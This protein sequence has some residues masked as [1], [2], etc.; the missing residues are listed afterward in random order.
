MVAS[1]ARP[2]Y[3]GCSSQPPLPAHKPRSRQ[4]AYGH[5]LPDLWA[6]DALRRGPSNQ[7]LQ[8]QQGMA[9]GEG[10]GGQ[11]TDDTRH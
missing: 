11:R 8:L 10:H 4:R 3:T 9:C 2:L 7:H 1:L 6:R 5:L